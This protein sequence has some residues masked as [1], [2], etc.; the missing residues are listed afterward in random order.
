MS[1]F[2]CTRLWEEKAAV[3]LH[4]LHFGYGVGAL[5]APQLALPFI[6]QH[7][8]FIN[9]TSNSVSQ[10]TSFTQERGMYTQTADVTPLMNIT[11][12][13]A[14]VPSRHSQIEIPYGISGS[15]AVILCISFSVFH[16]RE[17]YMKNRKTYHN[18]PNSG[19]GLTQPAK[20]KWHGCCNKD[21]DSL[22]MLYLAVMFLTFFNCNGVLNAFSKFLYIFATEGDLQMSHTMAASLNSA[23]WLAF[24]VGRGLGLVLSRWISPN[25]MLCAEVIVNVIS[26]VLLFIWGDSVPLMLWIN[27]CVFGLSMG[28]VIPTAFACANLY[29]RLNG[30]VVS[31]FFISVASG[32]LVSQWLT[33]YLFQLYGPKVHMPI[34]LGYTI[35]TAALLII[36]CLLI[37]NKRKRFDEVLEIAVSLDDKKTPAEIPN[38]DTKAENGHLS[39]GHI[40]SDC[41]RLSDK[42]SMLLNA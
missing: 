26:G 38:N 17:T 24:T 34:T 28:P 12:T 2:L 4:A 10:N 39:S 27:S 22:H 20:R 37:R 5:I 25:I 40:I 3:P 33:G 6:A 1:T 7:I 15:F 31:V 11:M 19:K 18:I 35:A 32:P 9:S 42:G 13:G 23:F 30:T 21:N 16:M 8:P 36:M 41:D 14:S 29:T